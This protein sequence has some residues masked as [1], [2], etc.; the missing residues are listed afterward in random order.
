MY[1]KISSVNTFIKTKKICEDTQHVE[2]EDLL[3]FLV[4]NVQ[5]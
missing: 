1:E 3:H 5:N 2:L 4:E